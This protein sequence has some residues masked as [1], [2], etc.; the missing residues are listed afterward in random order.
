LNIAQGV[1]PSLVPYALLRAKE[2]ASVYTL[3][4]RM[5]VKS[6]FAS[7]S[8]A[9]SCA[10]LM[11]CAACGPEKPPM[12]EDAPA[13]SAQAPQ[14]GAASGAVKGEMLTPEMLE[15]GALFTYPGDRGKFFDVSKRE[16]IPA[17]A[18]GYVRVMLSDPE[19]KPP[20]GQVWVAN[21][22]G[23]AGADG[24]QL[25]T[26]SR[27]LFEEF[28]LGRGAHS[29]VELPEGL[30]LPDVLPPT[31]KVIVYKTEWCGVCKKVQSYLDR[32]KVPYEAKDIEK[33][34]AAAAELKAKA[35]KAG[36]QTGSV[37]VI[38]VG[39]ELLVGFDRARL[40]KML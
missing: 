3:P 13:P 26:V 5:S 31:E 14:K 9:L 7:R 23:E 34:R 28:A 33:D 4:P 39:G 2:G 20:A 22:K 27:E 11:L 36:I 30:E 24:W 38:D 6:A 18:R 35:D 29:A 40:E 37:P 17:E 19:H 32:K 10:L 25:E 1:G 15:K 21:L 8:A 16:D 12:A